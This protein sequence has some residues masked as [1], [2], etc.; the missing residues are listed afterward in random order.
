MMQAGA[1]IP[2]RRLK[3]QKP[4]LTFSGVIWD[5]TK[6]SDSNNRAALKPALRF[7]ISI[8]ILVGTAK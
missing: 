1:E 4:R 8:G 7:F 6:I 3:K 5:S 2:G